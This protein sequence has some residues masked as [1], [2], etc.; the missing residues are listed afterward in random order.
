M[1]ALV[2]GAVFAAVGCR[3]SALRL[4]ATSQHSA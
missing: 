4:V 1:V 3:M 2:L